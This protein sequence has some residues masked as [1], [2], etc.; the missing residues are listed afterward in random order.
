MSFRI[1][2][3]DCI[4]AMRGMDEASVDAVVC[5]PPY[6]LGFMSKAWDR[7]DGEQVDPAFLHWF[8]GFVDGE[9]CFSVHRKVV[10]GCEVFDCQFSIT[11]RADDRP[12]LERI[13][14]T[15]GMGT[16]SKPG[17]HRTGKDNPK[18]RYSISRKA[19]C[20]RLRDLLRAFP[21]RAKK[22]KDLELW[23]DA[24]D[25]WVEHEPGESWDDVAEARSLLMASRAYAEEGIRVD[26]FQMWCWRWGR[27]ALRVLKPGG[28]ILAFGGSRTYHRLTAGLEDAGFEVRD[29]LA[30]LYGSGFPKSL[31]VSKAIDKRRDDEPEIREVC[32]FLR[33]SIEGSPESINLIAG[34]FGFHPRM[35]EHWAARD[36]DS[37]PTLPTL[38]QWDQLR[39][40]LGF[41]DSRDAEVLR[42]NL[43]KGEPGE[44]WADRPVTGEVEEWANRSNYALT[45]R[46][47]LR[48]DLPATPEAAQ[49]QGWGTAL[50]PAHEPIVLARK[51]LTGTVAGNVLAHGTGALNV[52]GC[53]VAMSDED[54]EVVNS[55][56]GGQHEA[57]HWQ[58]PGKAREVGE[59]F[60]SA[61][62]GRWPANVILDPEAAARLDAEAGRSVSRA[63]K[64]RSGANGDGW[65]M[66]ST[67]AEYDDEGGPS[68][69]FYCAKASRAERNAGLEGFRR[70]SCETFTQWVNEGQS[71][72]TR[73]DSATPLAR[74]TT[75]PSSAGDSDSSTIGSGSSTTG[76]SPKAS[77][78]TTSTATS[79][80]TGSKTS[81]SS[82][83][84]RT[85]EPTPP[86]TGTGTVNGSGAA[87]S[88]ASGSEPTPSITTSTETD[89]S[90]TGAAAPATSELSS[91]PSSSVSSEQP[92][93]C[94]DCGGVV[95]VD[96]KNVHPLEPT[97]KPIALMRWLVRLVTPPDGTVLDPFAGSG[98]T[99]IAAAL[100]GFDFIG[101]ERE[102][103][104]VE[105]A[106]ARIAHW[107][108]QP[109]Q[110]TFGEAA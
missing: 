19:H 56:S 6:A 4:E 89:G 67:G 26:P 88:A 44:A 32:R 9:G 45:S 108:A 97:V 87:Q 106:E 47:G 70:C 75:A 58:G 100:E 95:G 93:S 109:K 90:N 42:L 83:R 39:D 31:D 103:E 78:S 40:L 77:T 85:S 55:R 63:G 13:H 16:L 46:D 3:G 105:I 81:D 51:P 1:I 68:R 74:A 61:E 59:R 96:V 48:R 71:P 72:S 73:A 69:F 35:V 18:A 80:T 50:K 52:D 10:N 92:S 54:R 17:A 41:D 65:G 36:S 24:L 43:R 99:G 37:Q 53:R 49:W 21:L 38:E 29:C 30:W 11:L 86:T 5:D 76:R 57:E 34:R 33:R 101:I 79:R 2:E 91:K 8:A 102:A 107:A 22:A 23:S 62:G 12:I 28:H 110:L 25:A 94:P 84:S 20:L 60:T 7:V 98:T 64:P 15:L 27:E 66:T 104:Y 82:T 14:R